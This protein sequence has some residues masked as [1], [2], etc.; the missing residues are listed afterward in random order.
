MRFLLLLVFLIPNYAMSEWVHII[1][2]SDINVAR[3]FCHDRAIN[4]HKV[5]IIPAPQDDFSCEAWNPPE[6]SPCTPPYTYV[7]NESYSAPSVCVDSNG[8]S[9]DRFLENGQCVDRCSKYGEN[10]NGYNF[11]TGDCNWNN[12]CGP[13]QQRS[14]FDL[15]SPN[16]LGSGSCSER[17]NGCPEGYVFTDIN[18][19]SPACVSVTGSD[20]NGACPAGYSISSDG[21]GRCF[22]NESSSSSSSTSTSTSTSSSSTS[23]STSTSSSTS[24]TSSSGISSSSSGSAGTSSGSPTS[25]GSA[26]SSSGTGTGTGSEKPAGESGS[27]SPNCNLPPQCSDSASIACATL[28]QTWAAGC[29]LIGYTSQDFVSPVDGGKERFSQLLTD[30][31]DRVS[32]A[33]VVDSF[34]GFLAFNRS[35]SCPTWSVTTGPFVVKLDHWCSP[36]VP[37]NVIKGVLLVCSLLVAYRIAAK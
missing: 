31:S 2:S 4:G 15:S 18:R 22:P 20:V 23:T 17:T 8:C 3:G 16:G 28:K 34:S 11:S 13:M 14:R 33:P 6:T 24:S 29:P 21:T 26:S 1:R 30:F 5:R 25:S 36:W 37:W 32:Q 27:Y 7:Q 10:A 9:E 19:D 35:G 12:Q